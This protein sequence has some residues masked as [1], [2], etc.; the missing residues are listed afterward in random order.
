M[1]KRIRADLDKNPDHYYESGSG[2]DS[3]S[4]RLSAWGGSNQ[5]I[6]MR[7]DKL[8]SLKKALLSSYQKAIVQKYN[9]K[10]DSLAN[11]LIS[12]ITLLQDKQELSENQIGILDSLE[13]DYPNLSL[14]SRDE[15]RYIHLLEQIVDSLTTAEPYFKAL[16]NH[17][18]LKV[19]YEDK[20]ISIPF[21]EA[22]EG[23]EEEID[24]DF[25]NG[26]VFKWVHGNK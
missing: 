10:K 9:V 21:K 22:P 6:R 25:H 1:R 14:Y 11:N 4:K 12:I 5:W 16:I 24:T 23:S 7:E 13:N 15:D 17:D 20:I 8:R 2:L 18:K 19:D 26:T 3:M